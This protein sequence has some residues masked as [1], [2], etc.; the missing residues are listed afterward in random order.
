MTDSARVWA[1]LITFARCCE[2][3]R[4]CVVLHGLARTRLARDCL[5]LRALQPGLHLIACICASLL[6]I[7]VTTFERSFPLPHMAPSLSLHLRIR[8]SS[9]LHAFAT[10]CIHLLGL[11][12]PLWFDWFC[13]SLRDDCQS[14][15]KPAAGDLKAD[16][17]FPSTSV[18]P[19]QVKGSGR[20]TS[21]PLSFPQTCLLCLDP[22][23]AAWMLRVSTTP[24]DV[25]ILSFGL[26]AVPRAW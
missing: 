17:T 16:P 4:T 19:T 25:P 21:K 6:I 22:V 9:A 12:P 3:W 5:P 24:I 23:S 7:A 2:G 10:H 26:T 14:V 20:L 8:M 13:L 11:A 1:Y 18:P 15:Y